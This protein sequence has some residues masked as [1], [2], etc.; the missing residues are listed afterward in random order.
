MGQFKTM[1]SHR[2]WYEQTGRAGLGRVKKLIFLFYKS[3][4]GL[5]RASSFHAGYA[6]IG[7]I[8]GQ[9]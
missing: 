9:A 2:G 4:M 6:K 7:L 1:T 5:A 3:S 8:L